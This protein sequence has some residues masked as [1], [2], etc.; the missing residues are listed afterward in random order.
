MLTQNT[1]DYIINVQ[2]KIT[3]GM[4]SYVLLAPDKELCHAHCFLLITY[5]LNQ[6][7]GNTHSLAAE[8]FMCRLGDAHFLVSK[9]NYLER[10]S[11]MRRIKEKKYLT[12]C[13]YICVCRRTDPKCLLFSPLPHVSFNNI[14]KLPEIYLRPESS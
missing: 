6:L 14:F 13:M 5:F 7:P 11:S 1:A 3:N 8:L 12:G 9:G 4:K 10:F 2:R